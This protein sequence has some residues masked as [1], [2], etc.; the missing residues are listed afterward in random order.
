MC[1]VMLVNKRF[2]L[3]WKNTINLKNGAISM[4][5]QFLLLILAFLM[6]LSACTA[7]TSSQPT[8]GTTAQNSP[9][10]YRTFYFESYDDL[11]TN[12]RECG[13]SERLL[14]DTNIFSN[15][16]PIPCLNGE[17]VM[18]YHTPNSPITVFESEL[19][20]KPWIWYDTKIG[21]SWVVIRIML[22]Q[23]LVSNF[24]ATS[25]AS[26]I[27]RFIAPEAPNVDNYDPE[28]YASIA[29]KEIVTSDGAKIALW[30]ISARSNKEYISLMQ[31]N[32]FVV[33]DAPQGAVTDEWLASF[34]IISSNAAK[35]EYITE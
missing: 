23:E 31:N 8:A 5:K 35:N 26:D 9:P 18:L 11:K 29:D 28:S 10:R 2:L 34:S 6:L 24:D 7:G 27:V 4:K 3:I 20:Y 30:K 15:G 14:Q 17:P 32:Y 21:D 13:E 1:F 33:I 16:F 19:Y 12:G 22:N 25:F